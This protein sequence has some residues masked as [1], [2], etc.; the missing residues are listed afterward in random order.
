MKPLYFPFTY[1]SF[2]TAEDICAFFKD[3]IICQPT[4]S[5]VHDT[6][7]D[8]EKKGMI[9]I[10]LPVFKDE[11]DEKKLAGIISQI[12]AGARMH[13]CGDKAFAMAVSEKNP[14]CS[15]TLPNQVRSQINKSIKSE[16]SEELD[17]NILA[18]RAFLQIAQEMDMQNNEINMGLTA[19]EEM[20]QELMNVL[21]GD[22]NAS[23]NI[24]EGVLPKSL[25]MNSYIWEERLKAWSCLLQHDLGMQDIPLLLTTDS[26]IFENMI[27][28]VETAEKIGFFESVPVLGQ[29]IDSIERWRNDLIEKLE[30]IAE[31]T[32]D[33]SAVGISPPPYKDKSF[34]SR[35]SLLIYIIP[36]KTF[37][38]LFNLSEKKESK[39]K[40]T[41]LCL[42]EKKN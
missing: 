38:E 2:E 41:F 23:D 13:G 33:G 22:E 16:A 31:N 19:V 21:K 12:K 1:I 6:M 3:V 18:A 9:D 17:E 27:E 7:R 5:G 14:F 28:E 26:S 36:G 29:R 35:V 39:Y 24:Q 20:R 25:G 10:N 15:D 40:N 34:K 30:R 11:K 37:R 42:V 4:C 8:M 32:W